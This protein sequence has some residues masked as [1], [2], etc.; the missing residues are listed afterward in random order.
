MATKNESGPTLAEILEALQAVHVLRR[1]QDRHGAAVDLMVH[2]APSGWHFNPIASVHDALHNLLTGHWPGQPV[3]YGD[4]VIW[5]SP[6]NQQYV[7]SPVI[8]AESYRGRGP[9]ECPR[10]LMEGY[11]SLELPGPYPV[12]RFEFEDPDKGD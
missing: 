10:P 6:G 3:L 8:R 12:G 11:H 1:L 5:Y 7:T 2:H 9:G 4:R